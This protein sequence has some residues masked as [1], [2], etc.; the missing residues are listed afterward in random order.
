MSLLSFY[1]SGA[2]YLTPFKNFISRPLNDTAKEFLEDWAESL[3]SE[4]PRDLFKRLL[5]SNCKKKKF[6]YNKKENDT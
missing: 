5:T 3:I 2:L 1:E 4:Y 6:S